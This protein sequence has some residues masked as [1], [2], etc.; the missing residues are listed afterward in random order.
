MDG[1]DRDPAQPIR[2]TSIGQVQVGQALAAG[3]QPGDRF[4][5]L[6]RGARCA[7][8]AVVVPM[9]VRDGGRRKGIPAAGQLG[10]EIELPP[11]GPDLRLAGTAHGG[12]VT[13]TAWFFALLYLPP[14]GSLDIPYKP[15]PRHARSPCGEG[16]RPRTGYAGQATQ[17]R[18]TCN[19][20]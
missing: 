10:I 15:T 11:G 6:S 8:C 19:C 20:A 16:G 5:G 3:D 12:Q 18:R 7:P 1:L 2:E 14:A 13:S 17:S 9:A 4:P